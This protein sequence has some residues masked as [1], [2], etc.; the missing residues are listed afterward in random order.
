LKAK[1]LAFAT[2][3]LM[4]SSLFWLWVKLPLAATPRWLAWLRNPELARGLVERHID[5]ASTR[6]F[7]GVR[8][9]QQRDSSPRGSVRAFE[10]PW[11]GRGRR[12]VVAPRRWSG[13]GLP[14]RM[15]WLG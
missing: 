10:E 4:T 13:N 6:W 15:S 7:A 11:H 5:T 2:L 12:S 14:A 3:W 1:A 8:A 9:R